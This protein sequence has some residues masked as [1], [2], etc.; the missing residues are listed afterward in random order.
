MNELLVA[1]DDR[2]GALETAGACADAG[3]GPVRV[4]SIVGAPETAQHR[5]RCIVI[6]LGSR[7]LDP[8]AAAERAAL[9]GGGPGRCAHK[10]DSTLRGVWAHELVA[11]H[12]ISGSR[13]LVVP[14]LP[15]LGRQCV[16]G[17]V[18]HDGTPVSEGP[19]ARDA[20]APVRSS[21]PADHLLAAGAGV[22]AELH[23]AT[24]VERW[25][26]SGHE[27][28][29]VCDAATDADLAAI[30][31]RWA[32]RRHVLLAGTAA[33][34]G[35]AATAV[36]GAAGGQPPRPPPPALL[37]PLLVACG[38]L[39]PAVREQAATAAAAGIHVTEVGQPLEPVV[40]TLV[41]GRPAILISALPIG[42]RSAGPAP[43]GREADEVAGAVRDAVAR[44]RQ[45]VA[46][47]S[48][49]VI[50]GDTAA[51]VLG[52]QALLVGGTLA[53]GV[54][55]GWLNQ[56]RELLVLTRAGGFGG[57]EALVDLLAGGLQP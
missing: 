53:P 22:V 29:A 6:D 7:H 36:A 35:A 39:H 14:A 24:A 1:A 43:P 5:S 26:A 2:T 54:P 45:R 9:V 46:L 50:G 30:G 47:G 13:V 15:A 10:I 8:D 31:A 12:R 4:L 56:E 38:S 18:L 51:A 57:P 33:S 19:A 41:A 28:Y 40:D 23:G 20:R 11:R 32:C 42:S 25:L 44:I 55:W 17:V 48:L 37:P 49:L 16:G 21:R 27:P 52:D 3:L 34:I